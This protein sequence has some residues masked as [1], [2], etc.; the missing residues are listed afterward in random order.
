MR[1]T[2]LLTAGALAFTSLSAKSLW[3]T[4]TNRERSMYADRK[5]NAVGDI[6]QV[7]IAEETIV[8]RTSSKTSSSSPNVGGAS[9]KSL[10]IP[11][12]LEDWVPPSYEISGTDTYSGS[13]SITD[14]NTLEAKVAVMVAD[15]LPN[16]NLIIEGARKSKANGEAQYIVFRGIVREDDIGLDNSVMSYN[17]LNASVEIIGEGDITRSQTKGWITRLLDIT[18][19][20]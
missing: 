3:N 4:P 7:T 18:N 8:N 9:L 1:I 15:V 17:I 2:I 6:L 14:A 10:V 19:P 16:G 20:Y 13:G 11:D 12:V 5:A